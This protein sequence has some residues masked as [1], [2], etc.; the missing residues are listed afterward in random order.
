MSNKAPF[1]DDIRP[2]HIWMPEIFAIKGGIQA[3]SA[4]LLKALQDLYPR[5]PY[6]V[7]LKNDIYNSAEADGH[8]ITKFSFAGSWPKELRSLYFA[9]LAVG[10]GLIERPEIIISTHAHFSTLAYY[11]KKV[12][13]IPYWVVAHGKD[14]WGLTNPALKI[15]LR[16]ADLILAVSA[17]TRNRLLSEQ[18][19]DQE[20]VA[21]LPGTMDSTRFNIESKP[22]YLMQRYGIAW[23]QPL[24]LTVSRLD[25]KEQYKGYDTVLRALP[26]VR[27][28]IPGVRYL[29]VGKGDDRQRIERMIVEL[30]LESCVTLAGYVPDKELCDHYNLC[31]VFAM[32]SKGE[33]FGIVFLE[34]MACGK[35]VMAGNKDG[36]V[37]ALRWGDLGI[38]VDP[39]NVEEIA[40]A[41]AGILNSAYSHPV[42]YSPQLLRRRVIGAYGFESFK[43]ILSNLLQSRSSFDLCG[44]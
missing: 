28:A 22:E 37:D 7:F 3:Y 31:D 15:A 36:S 23:G 41:L 6:H 32:P 43:S 44:K 30:R 9:L 10:R 12:A 18:Q 21:I 4:F 26:A 17:Y 11:L 14:V 1:N 20:K 13:G 38:L 42:I 35:P 8:S 33:G 25:S 39:D 40:S 2:A 27:Q 5:V 29:I 19:L 24:I 16:E 34:A